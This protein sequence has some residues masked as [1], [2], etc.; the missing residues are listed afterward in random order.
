M[1]LKEI[2]SSWGNCERNS[3]ELKKK[4]PTGKVMQINLATEV[5]GIN[6]H[7]FFENGGKVYDYVIHEI[8]DVYRLLKPIEGPSGVF[9]KGKY[10]SI[11]G[12]HASELKSPSRESKTKLE[13]LHQRTVH[14]EYLSLSQLSSAIT[15]LNNAWQLIK[16]ISSF[17]TKDKKDTKIAEAKA[18]IKHAIEDLQYVHD[19]L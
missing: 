1:K 10:Y 19:N 2:S 8:S 14:K 3:W 16:D 13:S 5:D 17:K 18:K 9:D 4:N 7:V 11:L 12:I 15:V 6:S